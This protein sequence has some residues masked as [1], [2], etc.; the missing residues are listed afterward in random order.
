MCASRKER[1]R[2][3]VALLVR[4]GLTYKERPDLGILKELFQSVY[5]EIVRGGVCRN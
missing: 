5:V 4:E 1:S 3:G 2:G